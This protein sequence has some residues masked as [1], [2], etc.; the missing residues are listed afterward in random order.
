MRTG[1]KS[2]DS[3]FRSKWTVDSEQWTAGR[4]SGFGARDSRKGKSIVHHSSFIVLFLFTVHCAL[5]T[6]LAGT[7]VTGTYDL[8]ANPHVMAAVGGTSEYGLVF[9]QRNKAVTY[10]GVEYGPSVVKAR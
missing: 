7:H 10:D 9:A 5:S 3:G 6:S 1:F 2:Q 4:N 8:G